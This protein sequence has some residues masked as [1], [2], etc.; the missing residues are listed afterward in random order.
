MRVLRFK[1]IIFYIKNLFLEKIYWYLEPA[2][3][4]EYL[5]LL[6]LIYEL[7]FPQ[8]L[9]KIQ[10]FRISDGPVSGPGP[11]TDQRPDNNKPGHHYL[12]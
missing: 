3:G 7:Y 10:L 1:Q 4:P 5:D 9:I 2:N 6:K 12:E 8:I 11:E